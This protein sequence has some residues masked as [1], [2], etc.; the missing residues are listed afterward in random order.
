MLNTGRLRTVRV[1]RQ[2][3]HVGLDQDGPVIQQRA[4]KAAC[5]QLAQQVYQQLH[6]ALAVQQLLPVQGASSGALRPPLPYRV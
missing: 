1:R 2:G 4:H 6:K 5:G 3:R